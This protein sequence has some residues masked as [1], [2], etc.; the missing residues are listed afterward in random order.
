MIAPLTLNVPNS[1]EF[2]SG[3]LATLPLHLKNQNRIFILV[4]APIRVRINPLVSELEKAGKAVLVST[5]VV[6]EPPLEALETLLAPVRAFAPDAIVGIGGGS[7]MDLAKLVA[8]LFDGSQKTQDII[9]VGKVAGRKIRLISVSTTAGTGS[10]VTPIAILTDTQAKLKKGVVSPYLIPDVAIVDPDLT[11]SLPAAVTAATGMDAMTHCIESYT[12]RYAHPIVDNLAIDGMRLIAANLERCIRDGSDL[13]ARTAM[14]LG[15]LYGGLCLGPVNTA[16]VHAMA[17]PLGGTF[18]VSHGVSN[19]VLLPFVMVFNLS[20]NLKKYADVALAVGAPKGRDDKETAFNG[21][22]Q[23]REISKACGIPQSLKELDI[24]ESAIPEMA[25]AALLV[26]RLMD[27]NP[28]KVELQDAEA[29]YRKAYH[30]RVE[31]D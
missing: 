8:V 23:I 26:T 1:I 17:Y 22:M 24:P 25:K 28:R 13:E 21:V 20:G 14:S 15:S 7:A 9:G 3:K 11:L 19:S 4:D 16:A 29:I 18:K 27:N 30:G 6:P 10:E 31:R 2:G 12:N 5:E